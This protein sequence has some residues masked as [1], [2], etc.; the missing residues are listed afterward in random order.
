MRGHVVNS[1]PR[2]EMDRIREDFFRWRTTPAPCGI[3]HVHPYNPC[4][5]ER[6]DGWLMCINC[7]LRQRFEI[8]APSRG[9]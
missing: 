6:E 3:S 1:L 2:H 5:A 4:L 9:S 8:T 7:G